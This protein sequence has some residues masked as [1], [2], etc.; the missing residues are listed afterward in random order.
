MTEQDARL[1]GTVETIH[2]TPGP[3][4]GGYGVILG[5]DGKRYVWSARN[6]FRNFSILDTV[7]AKVTFEVVAYS[8]ATNID[9]TDKHR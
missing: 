6:V 9:R 7:G 8:Y 2:D 5:D 4:G 3:Y 1:S